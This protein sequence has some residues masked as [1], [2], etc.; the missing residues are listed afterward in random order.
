[1]PAA[2]ISE[3]TVEFGNGIK[4]EEYGPAKTAKVKITAVVDKG[5]DATVT[6]AY[7]ARLCQDK[8]REMLTIQGIPAEPAANEAAN[9]AEEPEA[10]RP[11]R[12]RKPAAQSPAAS[13]PEPAP[14]SSTAAT[15]E[16]SEDPKEPQVDTPATAGTTSG[17]DEW[18]VEAP[19]VKITDQDLLT[20]LSSAA[21]RLGSRDPINN[22]L[23]EFLPVT[24]GVKR[25]PKEMDDAVRPRFLERLNGL[26]QAA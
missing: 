24:A 19:P 23:A 12:G 21:E 4:R 5:Q 17:E 25:S 8:V 18:A 6:L 20:A 9:A 7:V 14:A 1:M 10:D 11:R 16:P 3:I 26:K 2:D 13:T 22:L 15:T